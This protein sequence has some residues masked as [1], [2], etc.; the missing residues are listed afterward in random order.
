MAE[1]R[2]DD[3]PADEARGGIHG[4]LDRFR[5]TR[6]GRLGVRIAV[7]AVGGAV[8]VA[9]LIMI[10]FPGPGWAVVIAGLAILALEY[11]WAHHLMSFTSRQVKAWLHWVGRQ[12]LAVRLLIG[13]GCFVFVA[14]ILWISLKLSFGF[15]YIQWGLGELGTPA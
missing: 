13:L 3:K 4:F 6:M 2:T 14:A 5:T 15:D 12:H 7:T 1:T 9:G 10:P 11:V 8:V